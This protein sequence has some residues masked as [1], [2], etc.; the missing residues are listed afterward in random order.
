MHP[1]TT[2]H[3]IVSILG[4]LALAACA[5]QAT[6]PTIGTRS[7]VLAPSAAEAQKPI[8]V[9]GRAVAIA[10]A[11][12]NVRTELR[13]SMRASLL[14]SHKLILREY[15][16]TPEGARLRGAMQQALPANADVL[17]KLLASLPALELYLPFREQRLTWQGGSEIIVGSTLDRSHTPVL[18]SYTTAGQAMDLARRDG[19]PRRP[20]LLVT[21][22]TSRNIRFQP[23]AAVPGLTVQDPKDGEESGRVT[24]FNKIDGTSTT[25]QVADILSRKSNA[26][27]LS[28]L[29]AC[30]A[31]CSGG[32]S[33]GS[34][35]APT[36]TT[37][38]RAF[39]IYWWWDQE[40]GDHEVY[41]IGDFNRDGVPIMEAQ[42]QR[43]GIDACDFATQQGQCV[44]WQSKVPGVPLFIGPRLRYSNEYIH[45]RI[46]EDNWLIPDFHGT[47]DYTVGLKA[48]W[49]PMCNPFC[50]TENIGYPDATV[51]LDWTTHVY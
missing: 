4:I 1:R 27:A 22:S 21:P 8:D 23:Q 29:I 28:Y 33:I 25:L 20:L 5:D 41:F 26:P 24:Y 44:A 38:V 9:L 11:D 34:P 40:W 30:D 43:D 15:F 45:L 51:L 32:G 35:A 37:Y 19:V 3:S 7:N 12:R 18:R 31:Q 46:Y 17:D 47:T 48:K 49:L 16:A 13:N 14:T 36:D 50:M 42:Y 6:G 10:L 39:E 2:V